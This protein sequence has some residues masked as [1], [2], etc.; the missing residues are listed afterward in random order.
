MIARLVNLGVTILA[1]VRLADRRPSQLDA[2]K[3]LLQLRYGCVTVLYHRLSVLNTL[4]QRAD[5]LVQL[6][7]LLVKPQLVLHVLLLSLLETFDVAG[8]PFRR[9]P[10]SRVGGVGGARQWLSALL[11]C[12]VGEHCKPV[13][14]RP[15]VRLECAEAF[16]M[17][18]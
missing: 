9:P 12:E 4:F 11:K 13:V 14:D 15:K 5:L 16:S 2:S 10:V 17:L 1:E 7:D 3:L 18:G 8:D 6:L